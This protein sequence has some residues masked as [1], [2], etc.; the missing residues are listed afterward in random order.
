MMD[1]SRTLIS[2]SAGA[3]TLILTSS[4]TKLLLYPLIIYVNSS[5]LSQFLGVF[6]VWLPFGL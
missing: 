3:T 5:K 4:T 6:C 2:L 1:K